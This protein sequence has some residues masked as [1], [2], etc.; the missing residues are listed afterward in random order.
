MACNVCIHCFKKVRDFEFA[1]VS[2]AD[3]AESEGY[4]D[5]LGLCVFNLSVQL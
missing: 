1:F 5:A 3:F 4:L 2:D